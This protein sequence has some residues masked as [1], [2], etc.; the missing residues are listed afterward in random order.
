MI[1]HIGFAPKQKG[2]FSFKCVNMTVEDTICDA[3][4]TII[5]N[6][7]Y[8]IAVGRNVFPRVPVLLDVRIDYTKQ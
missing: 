6:S 8:C 2:E 5:F 3:L 1:D 4:P 7:R